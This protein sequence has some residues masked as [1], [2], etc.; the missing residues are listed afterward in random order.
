MISKNPNLARVRRLWD[1]PLELDVGVARTR[2]DLQVIPVLAEKVV[3][4]EQLGPLG[5]PDKHLVDNLGSC[6]HARGSLGAVRVCRKRMIEDRK[7]LGFRDREGGLTSLE[8][9][10]HDLLGAEGHVVSRAHGRVRRRD[11]RHPM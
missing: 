11:D 8:L 10:G 1:L 9:G 6:T 7:K 5:R 2:R 3:R 4:L